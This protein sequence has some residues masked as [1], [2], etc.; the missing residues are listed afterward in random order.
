MTIFNIRNSFDSDSNLETDTEIDKMYGFEAIVNYTPWTVRFRFYSI[1]HNSMQ[2]IIIKKKNLYIELICVLII[3]WFGYYT[4]CVP[5]KYERD[6]IQRMGLVDRDGQYFRKIGNTRCTSEYQKKLRFPKY[7]RLFS[8]PHTNCLTLFEF[9]YRPQCFFRQK[10]A[11]EF[12]V[13]LR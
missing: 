3:Y 10:V 2:I 6:T 4:Q 9:L 5:Y 11:W 7:E 13:I 8:V 12:S 1:R